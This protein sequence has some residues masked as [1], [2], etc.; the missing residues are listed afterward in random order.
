MFMGRSRYRVTRTAQG[1]RYGEVR[2]YIE[3]M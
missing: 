3:T 2:R 1:G